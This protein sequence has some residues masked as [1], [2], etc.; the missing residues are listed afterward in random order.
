MLFRVP[1]LK[2]P[3]SAEIQNGTFK[4]CFEKKACNLKVQ[5]NYL[6]FGVDFCFCVSVTFIER[7]MF[8]MYTLGCP[9]VP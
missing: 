5:D 1:S 9:H 8:N 2:L 4:E 6:E 7:C 3:I